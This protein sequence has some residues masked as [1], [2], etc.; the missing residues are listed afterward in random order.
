MPANTTKNITLS[1]IVP[2]GAENNETITLVAKMKGSDEVCGS[3][4]DAETKTLTIHG[5]PNIKVNISRDLSLIQQKGSVEYLA[6]LI[7][8]GNVATPSYMVGV[9]PDDMK[10]DLVK[11]AGKSKGGATLDCKRC[12]VYTAPLGTIGKLPQRLDPNDPFE[13]SDMAQYFSPATDN[14]DGTRTPASPD[15]KYIIIAFDGDR[16]VLDVGQMKKVTFLTT[17]TNHKKG[18][19]IIMNVGAISRDLPQTIANEVVTHIL[20]YPG[21][22]VGL[23]ATAKDVVE[24]CEV[25]EIIV[26]YYADIGAENEKLIVTTSIPQELTI[27]KVTNMWNEALVSE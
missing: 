9:I 2:V 7:N 8:I 22:Q 1:L 15:A 27:T 4:S 20:D 24:S 12:K 26:D 6:S 5:V 3:V 23:H 18:D 19:Q 14:G 17:D 13:M 16:S 11:T 10:L 21:A 25:N